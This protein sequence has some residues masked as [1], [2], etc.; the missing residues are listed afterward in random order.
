VIALTALGKLVNTTI[1][2]ALYEQV[3]KLLTHTTD[4]VRKKAIIVLQK[5]H[6]ISPST[7]LDYEDKMKRALCDKEPSVMGAVL[8]LYHEVCKENAQ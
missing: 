4:L 1:V 2:N 7:I 8:N 3:S 6:K 5:I